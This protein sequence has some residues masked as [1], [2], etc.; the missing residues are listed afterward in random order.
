M[1]NPAAAASRINASTSSNRWL[2]T[3]L[4]VIWPYK[5]GIQEVV[6]GLKLCYASTEKII[7]KRLKQIRAYMNKCLPEQGFLL[8]FDRRKTVTWK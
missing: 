2:H 1:L 8:T 4:L 7:G 5:G 6:V 3:D